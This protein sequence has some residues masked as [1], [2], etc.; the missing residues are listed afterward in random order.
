MYCR[1]H[2]HMRLEQRKSELV[3]QAEYRNLTASAVATSTSP[4]A[5]PPA[6]AVL[7]FLMPTGESLNINTL[8]ERL[9]TQTNACSA[10]NAK[11][12]NERRNS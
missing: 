3:T 5:P 6:A 11:C 2:K 4:A 12:M 1:A 7:T 10:K 9:S 8:L